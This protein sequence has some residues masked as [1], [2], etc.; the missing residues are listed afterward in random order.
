MAKRLK[1]CLEVLE[2][3]ALDAT[4]QRFSGKQQ[5]VLYPLLLSPSATSTLC[6]PFA[7]LNHRHQCT[8]FLPSSLS[9]SLSHTIF[10][11]LFRSSFSLL[12]I[13]F[14]CKRMIL[15]VSTKFRFLLPFLYPLFPLSG[16]FLFRLPLTLPSG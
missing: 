4:R 12:F 9:L 7:T 15:W 1:S 2:N 13:L 8:E 11:C 5:F 6:P 14:F 16:L 3:P 10:L